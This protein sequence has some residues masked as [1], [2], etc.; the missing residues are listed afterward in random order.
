MGGVAT[1]WTLTVMAWHDGLRPSFGEVEERRT[2]DAS[3]ATGVAFRALR[4]Y[5]G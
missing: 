2:F 5:R 4:R 1:S 3:A